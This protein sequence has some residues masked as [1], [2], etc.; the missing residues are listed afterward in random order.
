MNHCKKEQNKYYYYYY[1]TYG[2]THRF[3]LIIS[4]R[5]I[6]SPPVFA[7]AYFR[8]GT[9]S[10]FTKD[11]LWIMW[12]EQMRDW[13]E[14]Q[15]VKPYVIIY[16]DTPTQL[17]YDRLVSDESQQHCKSE[18]NFLREPMLIHMDSAYVSFLQKTDIP[19]HTIRVTN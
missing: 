15:N 4:D 5:S 11:S 12:E 13:Y 1:I 2:Q 16:L 9:F 8:H 7:N 14:I 17:A 18:T 3:Y 19:H 10:A 6:L